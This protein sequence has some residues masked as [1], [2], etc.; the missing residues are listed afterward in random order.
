MLTFHHL[1]VASPDLTAEVDALSSLGYSAVGAPFTDPVLGV[2]GL[3]LRGCGPQLEVLEQLPGSTVLDGWLARGVRIYHEAFLAEPLEAELQKLQARGARL[4]GRPTPAV[5]FEG[6]RVCF[7]MLRG[8]ILT[9]LVEAGP[10][11]TP[12]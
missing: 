4:I 3:F 5:A 12:A 6:R 11:F 2:R 7:V 10:A 1:G 9:E 8:S